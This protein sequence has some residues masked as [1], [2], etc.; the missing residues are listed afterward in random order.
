[1]FAGADV[2][3][4]SPATCFLVHLF[5]VDCVR[6][7]WPIIAV[8][9]FSFQT[10]NQHTPQP[11][12]VQDVDISYFCRGAQEEGSPRSYDLSKILEQ[13]DKFDSVNKL[14]L[15]EK[16][17]TIHDWMRF[18]SFQWCWIFG[19]VGELKP[20]LVFGVFQAA[21]RGSTNWFSFWFTTDFG[22]HQSPR[23]NLSLLYPQSG[24]RL[25]VIFFFVGGGGVWKAEEAFKTPRWWCF[26]IGNNGKQL[27]TA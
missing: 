3:V 11:I 9:L 7:R 22:C 6:C 15:A 5:W 10:P 4:K 14:P 23:Q 13:L 24:I 16:R 2:V 12:Q 8:R 20:G 25:R 1:M 21:P 18:G 17:L 26:L 27:W 19:V